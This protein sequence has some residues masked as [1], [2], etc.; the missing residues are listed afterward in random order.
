MAPVCELCETRH[1]KYQAHVF[2][3]PAINRAAINV[4]KLSRVRD[5][6]VERYGKTANRRD[7]KVYNEYMRRKMREYRAAKKAAKKPA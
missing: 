4:E 5:A 3:K 1:E 6:V 2:S 7:R